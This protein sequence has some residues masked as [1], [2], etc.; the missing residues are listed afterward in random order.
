MSLIVPSDHYIVGTNKPYLQVEVVPEDKH[1][2]GRLKAYKV[3]L[4]EYGHTLDY[5]ED[6]P[7]TEPP[8]YNKQM[9][10]KH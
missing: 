5:F 7:D 8:D 2:W 9:E 3:L 1:Y 4:K 6:E 10:G